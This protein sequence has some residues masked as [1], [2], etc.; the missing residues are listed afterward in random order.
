MG[1]ESWWI[2]FCMGGGCLMCSPPLVVFS[3]LL[4]LLTQGLRWI[5]ALTVDRAPGDLPPWWVLETLDR[6]PW[7]GSS[8]FT[9]SFRS[10]AAELRSVISSNS[11]LFYSQWGDS[12]TLIPG[13]KSQSWGALHQ[14]FGLWSQVSL[15]PVCIPCVLPTVDS[16]ACCYV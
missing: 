15:V 1:A 10:R 7:S 5:V 4:L 12:T 3:F 6:L 9:M 14:F 2:I 11:L 16:P 8:V 13:Q